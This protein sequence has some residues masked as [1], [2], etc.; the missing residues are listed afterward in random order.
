MP[1]PQHRPKPAR[2]TALHATTRPCILKTAGKARPLP[3][4]WTQPSVPAPLARSD[5]HIA[6]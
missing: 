3:P 4:A 1:Q 5:A 6:N 2:L